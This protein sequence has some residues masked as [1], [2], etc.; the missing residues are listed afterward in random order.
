MCLLPIS[1]S[2]FPPISGYMLA[3]CI[4]FTVGNSL[5]RNFVPLE[6]LIVSRG[7]MISDTLSA[8]TGANFLFLFCEGIKGSNS[9]YE[10]F[11]FFCPPIPESVLLSLFFMVA[12]SCIPG[13]LSFT[14]T[15]VQPVSK[16]VARG[17]VAPFI[18]IK[19]RSDLPFLSNLG[20]TPAVISNSFFVL[21]NKGLS[22][23]MM[24]FESFFLFPPVLVIKALLF[25]HVN[26]NSKF[27]FA[28][29]SACFS[30][31]TKFLSLCSLQTSFRSGHPCSLH[32][33]SRFL[34]KALFLHSLNGL[35]CFGPGA[36][37]SYRQSRPELNIACLSS[38]VILRYKG[39]FAP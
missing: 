10:V 1:M 19:N 6:V 25:T 34:I 3:F 11:V 17:L 18:F 26:T 31:D 14:S 36:D 12:S 29:F 30:S 24:D 8:S 5:F 20:S 7:S 23:F 2:S 33:H 27:C 39:H 37:M 28:R 21:T 22:L 32:I 35:L 13:T 38:I 4:S 16:I 15:V 9:V